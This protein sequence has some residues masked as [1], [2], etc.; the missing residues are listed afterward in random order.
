MNCERCSYYVDRPKT[1]KEIQYQKFH[2]VLIDAR[3]CSLNG[4]DGSRFIDRDRK[5]S[6]QNERKRNKAV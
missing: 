4:C 6:N 3:I 5:R 1:P 2:G